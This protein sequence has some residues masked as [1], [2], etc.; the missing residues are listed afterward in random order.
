MYKDLLN[1]CCIQ[2]INVNMLYFPIDKYHVTEPTYHL[3]YIA[4]NNLLI[5]LSD[6]LIN[7]SNYD[8]D[9]YVILSSRC[10]DYSVMLH[11]YLPLN[12]PCNQREMLIS[13]IV[14]LYI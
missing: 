3:S 5:R 1:I 13:I 6:W 4:T 11:L 2:T 10:I 14:Y 12:L 8:N 9:G 7:E